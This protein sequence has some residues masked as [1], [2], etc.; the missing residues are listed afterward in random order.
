MDVYAC[1]PR[2]NGRSARMRRR[3]RSPH[4]P[5]ID[6]LTRNY[7]PTSFLQQEE[8]RAISL[9]VVR[10][11]DV[12]SE[13]SGGPDALMSHVDVLSINQIPVLSKVF[14]DRLVWLPWGSAVLTSPQGI[15]LRREEGCRCQVMWSE[16][17]VR[18]PDVAKGK[19]GSTMSTVS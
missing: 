7:R 14:P 13:S 2:Q 9:R 16:E 4:T 18:D 11:W 12:H 1:S 6:Q 5:S 8:R 17:S 15:C 3:C 19:A 10:K